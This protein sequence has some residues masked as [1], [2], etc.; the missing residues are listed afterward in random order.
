MAPS[1]GRRQLAKHSAGGFDWFT[2]TPPGNLYRCESKGVAGKAIRKTMKTKG[3]QNAVVGRD[4]KSRA[5][6]EGLTCGNMGQGTTAVYITKGLS[7][8]WRKSRLNGVYGL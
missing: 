8:E 1:P 4:A 5:S 2:P 6:S 3:A 7:I